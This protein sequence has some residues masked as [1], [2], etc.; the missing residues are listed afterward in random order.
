MLH[1]TSRVLLL[2]LLMF[3][4]IALLLVLPYPTSATMRAQPA[5]SYVEAMQRF[6]AINAAETKLALNPGCESQLL[7][8][9]AAT[10]PVA[11][12]FHGYRNCPLQFQRLGKR[13]HRLGYTVLIPRMPRMGF[14]SRPNDTHGGLSK[15]E[16]VRYGT[17]AMDIA[18]GLGERVTVVGFSA[19]GLMAAWAAQYRDD[20]ER[21]VIISPFMAPEALPDAFAR[22][23]ANLFGVIPNIYLWQDAELKG[24]TPNPAHV[25]QRNA[26]RA[27]SAL[28]Q[29]GFAVRRSSTERAPT[30]QQIVIIGNAADEVIDMDPVDELIHA[31]RQLG[32]NAIERFD[33]EKALGLDHDVV[34][35]SHP[36]AKVEITYPILIDYI[37][38]QPN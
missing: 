6:E 1:S 11:V 12:L 20:V 28:M 4:V 8:H 23:A 3:V 27:L 19:G 33:F 2:C 21:V 5:S 37:L 18:R 17:E 30:A 38:A 34:D 25:Y 16:L 22:P 14:A 10:G 15:D 31:W 9:G 36:K 7:E 32:Y 26:T 35:P 29:L 24:A 13:V